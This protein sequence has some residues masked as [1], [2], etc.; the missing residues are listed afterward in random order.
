[1]KRVF[2]ILTLTFGLIILPYVTVA[3]N[4]KSVLPINVQ[5]DKGTKSNSNPFIEKACVSSKH[6]QLCIQILKSQPESANADIKALAFI[7]LNVTKTYGATVADWVAQK[8]EDPELG[9]Q[10]EQALTDC[11]NQYTDAIT[12]LEDSLVAFFSNA[13]NDVKTWTSTAL[14]NAN[15]CQEGL[16]G[17]NVADVMGKRNQFFSEYC[18]IALDVVNEL[19]K[20]NL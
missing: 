3:L 8:L 18:S 9:P 7:S 5:L 12:Q 2:F 14:T 6:K 13:L 20:Q 17:A 1:M 16:N 15:T 11:S 10:L 4:V 19:A